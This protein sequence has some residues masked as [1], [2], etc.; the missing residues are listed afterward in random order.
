MVQLVLFTPPVVTK[1]ALRLS[2]LALRTTASASA[3]GGKA[4]PQLLPHPSGLFAADVRISPVLNP[5]RAKL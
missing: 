5:V 1:Y 3:T 4:R 2:A